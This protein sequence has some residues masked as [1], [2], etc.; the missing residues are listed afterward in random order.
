[1]SGKY[2]LAVTSVRT[3]NPKAI[4]EFEIGQKV[5]IQNCSERDKPVFSGEVVVVTKFNVTVKNKHNV[6]ESFSYVNFLTGHIKLL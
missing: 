6:K 5:R 2:D 1:M 4:P 3:Y